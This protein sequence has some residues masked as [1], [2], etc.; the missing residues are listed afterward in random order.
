MKR[1]NHRTLAAVTGQ[2]GESDRNEQKLGTTPKVPDRVLVV[3]D[4]PEILEPLAHSL[5]KA[6][7]NVLRAEDGLTACRAIGSEHPDLILL[8]IMLPDLDGW[9][10]CKLLRQHPDPNVSDIPVIM[11]TA[12]NS[13]HDKY[14]GLELGA[15]A[16]LPKPYAIREVLLQ[17]GNL[18]RRRRQ[19]VALGKRIKA[20]QN[21]EQQAF[22][23]H[24][25]L[26]HELRN[27]LLILNGY[28]ELLHKDPDH[29]RFQTCR[30]AIY[31]SAS[32]LQTLAEEVL[33]IRQ[34]G[35]GGL[36]LHTEAF[37][38]SD[39]I[40]EI[41]KVYKAPAKQKFMTLNHIKE[42]SSEFV[43]LNRTALKIIVS[44]LVDNAIKYGPNGQ[45]ITLVCSRSRGRLELIVKDHGPG[46]SLEDQQQIFEP[47]YRSAQHRDNVRG[48]G[49]GLHAVSILSKAMGGEATV[50]SAPG[51]GSS[52]RVSFP[53][54][55]IN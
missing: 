50:E 9:E 21:K 13:P 55:A 53:L 46:I 8:D 48:S 36:P 37:D 34:V 22:D 31:R 11:L 15:D 29:R 28:T 14:R 19:A 25:L 32:Y 5:Q 49:I 20:L 18:I 45:T 4:E 39:L 7:Y 16:F 17:A 26:F 43:R 2:P 44:A 23:M 30:D 6:G 24:H 40:D 27:Q 38:A 42:I 41:V 35:N 1:I 51:H 12:L 3:E 10:V 47:Y 52:F 54:Q 33:L